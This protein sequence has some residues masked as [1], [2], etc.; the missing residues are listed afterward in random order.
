[1]SKSIVRIAGQGKKCRNSLGRREGKWSRTTAAIE[2]RVLELDSR[3]RRFKR[4]SAKKLQALC[5]RDLSTYDIVG[6]FLDGKTFGD[7][8][9]IIALGVTRKGQKVVLGFVQTTSA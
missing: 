1:M 5:E 8:E 7:D 3:S 4:A 6:L 9:I 2:R